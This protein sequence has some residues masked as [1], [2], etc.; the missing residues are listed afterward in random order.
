LRYRDHSVDV[1]G[2]NTKDISTI[3]AGAF[4]NF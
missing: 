3:V 1:P 2:V 4:I